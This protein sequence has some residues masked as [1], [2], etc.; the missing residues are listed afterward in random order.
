MKGATNVRLVLALGLLALGGARALAAGEVVGDGQEQARVLLSGRGASSGG[1]QSGFVSPSSSGANA[2]A[3]DAQGQAREMIL[4]RQTAKTPIIEAG[5][6]RAAGA[7]RDREVAR[8]P[9][10]MARQMILGRQSAETSAKIR[11]TSHTP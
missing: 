11:L 1:L 2:I 8:D 5:G 6:M 10:E 7:R 4:G 9:H 3:L